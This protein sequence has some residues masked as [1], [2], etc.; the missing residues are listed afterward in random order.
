MAHTLRA[1]L[2]ARSAASV[3]SAL[4]REYSCKCASGRG[5]AR[6][7]SAMFTTSAVRLSLMVGEE[8]TTST[9][10]RAAAQAATTATVPRWL[11]RS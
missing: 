6:S 8:V 4:V 5:G 10:T 9:G 2:L 1:A 3:P 7:S 11:T